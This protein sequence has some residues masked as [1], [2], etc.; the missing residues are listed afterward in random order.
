MFIAA[1]LIITENC[2]QLRCH[3][4][5]VDEPI[6]V[7]SYNMISMQQLKRTNHNM[8]I[9]HIHHNMNELNNNYIDS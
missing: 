7:Y 5:R 3:H 8:N 6:V 2:K 9:H 4:R 1:L